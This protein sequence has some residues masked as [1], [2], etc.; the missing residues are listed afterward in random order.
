MPPS[1]AIIGTGPRALGALEA[2]A[3]SG[4]VADVVL[5]GPD[6]HPGAGPNFS[7]DQSPLGLLNIPLRAI[8]LPPAPVAGFPDFADWLHNPDLDSYPARAELGSYLAARFAAL[9]QDG[10]L[11]IRH[12]RDVITDI[13]PLDGGLQVAGRRFDAVLLTPGQ[14]KTRPDDQL[15]RWQTHAARTGADLVPAYPDDAL[16]DAARGWAGA[17]VGVRGL[18]LATLDVLRVLTEGLGG[19]FEAGRYLPSGREPARILPFSLNGL[20][21]FPKPATAALD[22][23][24]D[25]TDAE[26]TAFSAALARAVT[27][28]P[29]AALRAICEPLADA[30]G[31]ILG[32]RPDDWLAAE[33]EAPASQHQGGPVQTL[34]TAIAMARGEVAPDAGHVI[35]ALWRKWQNALRR[36]FNPARLPDATATALIGFDE[37]LKR[38]SYGP[39]LSAAERL[40]A[41]IEAGLV[42]LRATD[43]PDIRTTPQGW[44]LHEGRTLALVTAMVDAVLPSPRLDALDDPLFA[45]LDRQGLICPVADGM[46]ARLAADGSLIGADGQPVAGLSLLGRMGLGSIIAADSIH[47]CFG[48]SADRWAAGIA[49]RTGATAQTRATA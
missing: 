28:P 13:A 11:R 43:D 34:R 18:G 25:P 33:R 24:L 39:P 15:A 8:D 47:D 17:Q 1:L 12:Q 19:R 22:A 45:A 21:P 32:A 7:P 3:R 41:L 44:Q 46:G 29:E 31:R 27:L 2:L 42:D 14:P 30:S 35:G 20:P 6:P 49:A 36:G 4:V 16:L 9:V 26:T 5:F 23:A 38:Y 40:L 48:A 37:G 10:P